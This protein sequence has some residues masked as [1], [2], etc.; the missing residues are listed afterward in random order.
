MRG[1]AVQVSR[2]TFEMTKQKKFKT[3]VRA[4]MERDGL[5]YTQALQAEREGSIVDRLIEDRLSGSLTDVLEH[6][7][8]YVLNSP[9]HRNRS[10]ALLGS[11]MME[12]LW[13]LDIPWREGASAQEIQRSRKES[14]ARTLDLWERGQLVGGETLPFE[15][16]PSGGPQ[17]LK[18]EPPDLP[19]LEE[20]DAWYEDG[21]NDEHLIQEAD[22]LNAIWE[23][24]PDVSADFGLGER[25]K[26]QSKSSIAD[27]VRK[28]VAEELRLVLGS[29]KQGTTQLSVESADPEGLAHTMRRVLTE[30]G[31]NTNPIKK[32]KSTTNPEEVFDSLHALHGAAG[33]R[34]YAVSEIQRLRG[35]LIAAGIDPNSV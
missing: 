7:R 5:N 29:S 8:D 16:K 32:G 19:L 27:E 35:K 13:P 4:R 11:H 12:A 21:P 14:A 3:R 10:W 2:K 9:E 34:E 31:I 1:P 25:R 6:V 28:V 15:R 30:E 24:A 20:D 18:V 22:A 26:P 23:Y 17:G 33:A